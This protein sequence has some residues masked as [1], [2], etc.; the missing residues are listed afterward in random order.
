ERFWGPA[1]RAEFFHGHGQFSTKTYEAI[2]QQCSPGELALGERAGSPVSPGCRAVL[3]RMD[4]EI[5]FSFAYNLYDECYDFVLEQRLPRW[6]E[7]G[8]LGAWRRAGPRGSGERGEL[9]GRLESR[10]SNASGPGPEPAWHMD[11]QPCGGTAVLPVWT[12]HPEVREA[13]HVAPDA[14]YFYGDN[15]VGFTYVGT[16][17]DLVEDTYKRWASENMAGGNRTALRMLIYNGDTDPGL[18]SFVAER[19]LAD[20]GLPEQEG[21]RPWT[22]DGWDAKAGLK[23]GGYVTRYAG[24][25]DFV[26]I[27][28]SGHMV[29]EYKPEAAFTMIKSFLEGK[30]VP[31]LAPKPP[32]RR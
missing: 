4:E 19:W 3:D 1:Y 16:E 14:N 32:L 6:S 7:V 30:P 10:C 13:L 18:N 25:L 20:L 27:R 24:N 28:G 26:T 22:R 23:V 12:A 5:G 29:P 21:W 17:P 9:L 2:G 15:G 11:G 8:S 31:R